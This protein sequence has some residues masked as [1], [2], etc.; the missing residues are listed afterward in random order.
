[1]SRLNVILSEKATRQYLPILKTDQDYRFKDGD[2]IIKM[3]EY[4]F[5]FMSEMS[6]ILKLEIYNDATT[7]SRIKSITPNSSKSHS[8]SKSLHNCPTASL[9]PKPHSK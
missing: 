5:V 9:T 6:D 2:I 7:I 1:M 8:R 4:N 3:Y